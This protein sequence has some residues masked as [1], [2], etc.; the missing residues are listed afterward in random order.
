MKFTTK[1]RDLPKDF[2]HK[3]YFVDGDKSAGVE[4]KFISDEE[5]AAERKKYVKQVVEYVP[6]PVTRKLTK[7]ESEEVDDNG[8]MRWWVTTLIADF[9]GIFIDDTEAEVTDYNKQ[10][11]FFGRNFDE[12]GTFTSVIDEERSFNKF[13]A[14]KNIELGKI[15]EELFGGKSKRKNS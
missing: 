4:L 2:R 6:H 8:F 14:A 9:W 15:A 3:F 5:M 1:T 12:G 13:V 11:L 10:A 7:V